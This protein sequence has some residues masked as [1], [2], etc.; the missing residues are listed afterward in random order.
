MAKTHFYV[1]FFNGV[2]TKFFANFEKSDGK[3]SALVF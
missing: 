1:I 2:R 3:N